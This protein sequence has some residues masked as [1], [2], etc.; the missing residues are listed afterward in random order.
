[1]ELTSRLRLYVITDSPRIADLALRGGARA[2]QYREKGKET[3]ELLKKG[4]E[5]KRLCD[6]RG[7][8]F[9]VDD[10]IDIALALGADGVH[11]GREDMPLEIARELVG[12][13]IIGASASSVEEALSVEKTADYIGFGSIFSTLTKG[14]AVVTGIEPLVEVKRKVKIPVIAIGGI[15]EE[16]VKD[17]ARIA[18][19]VAVISAIS[20]A[21]DPEGATRRLLDAL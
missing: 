4:R 10:R 5:I 11:L 2:I 9:I 12:E 8:L 20:G 6:V 13:K 21:E 1:M 3:R 18:D 16:N 17:I 15:T 19:G 7:A 14:D